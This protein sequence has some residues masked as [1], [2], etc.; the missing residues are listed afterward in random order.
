MEKAILMAAG[1]GTRI[2]RVIGD[3]S[4]CALDIGGM[5][6]IR[7]TVLMLL[8]RGIE[9]HVVV[10]YNKSAIFKALEGLRV[11]YHENVFYSVT[12]SLASLWW[13][14][15]ELAGDSLILGNAD[16]FWEDDVLDTI[17]EETRD[18]VMLCDS[19]RV[20]QGDYLFNVTGGRITAYGKGMDCRNANCEYVGLARIQGGFVQKCKAKLEN[21]IECQRHGAWWEEIL[22]EMIPERPIWARD[23]AGKF[24]AEIDFIEDYIRILDYLLVAT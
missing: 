22:Y 9:A 6:L 20:E 12:N 24:W 18:C 15:E 3:N 1:R 17:L 19:S 2:S 10:G 21:M 13:A 23:I 11:K 8:R 5:S 16:V 14:K 4:K 7:H